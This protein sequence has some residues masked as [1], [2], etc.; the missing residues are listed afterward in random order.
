MILNEMPKAL[1]TLQYPEN[2]PSDGRL[3]LIHGETV[4][5]ALGIS[6]S[7]MRIQPNVE[8]REPP[9]MLYL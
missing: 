5:Q 4:V 7:A 9:R 3:T 1:P 2:D 8:L 6:L